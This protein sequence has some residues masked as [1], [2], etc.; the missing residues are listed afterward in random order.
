VGIALEDSEA[1]KAMQKGYVI[2]N[3]HHVSDK[4]WEAYKG[5]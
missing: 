3:L 5:I 1:A 4:V 2:D